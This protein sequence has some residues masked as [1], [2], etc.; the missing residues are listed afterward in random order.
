MVEIQV[1]RSFDTDFRALLPATMF[2]TIEESRQGRNKNGVR[3]FTKEN[4]VE[5][6]RDQKWDRVK[7]ICRELSKKIKQFGLAFVSFSSVKPNSVRRNDA[8]VLEKSEKMA[9]AVK[10][11]QTKRQPNIIPAWKKDASFYRQYLEKDT[12]SGSVKPEM[13][14]RILKM[15]STSEDGPRNEAS[16][17]RS[18]KMLIA[19][20]STNTDL[21]EITNYEPTVGNVPVN[22]VKDGLVQFRRKLQ[23][24]IRKEGQGIANA[25][26]KGLRSKFEEQ[27]GYKMDK[28]MKLEFKMASLRAA[29]SLLSSEKLPVQRANESKETPEQKPKR[30]SRPGTTK[31]KIFPE[32]EIPKRLPA[33]AYRNCPRCFVKFTANQINLHIANCVPDH[34][35]IARAALGAITGSSSP[36]TSANTTVPPTSHAKKHGRTNNKEKE[37]VPKTKKATTRKRA[38]GPKRPKRCGTR[39]PSTS[40]TRPVT[41][42]ISQTSG[43]NRGCYSPRTS[44]S[45]PQLNSR[46]GSGQSRPGPSASI[47]QGIQDLSGQTRPGPSDSIMQ[48]N[49]DLSGQT[50]PGPSASTMQ[51]NQELFP[52]P[53]CHDSYDIDLIQV[54]ASLCGESY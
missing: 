19:A 47:M 34:L 22:E 27:L 5:G 35:Q 41:Q 50:R 46:V 29:E 2:R 44:N 4:F 1:R 39:V 25:S 36:S 23:K 24:F 53:I 43:T 51:G 21:T 14:D 9:S 38:T 54:H 6:V 8:S 40:L 7:I 30:K 12:T 15:S 52:C 11:K 26:M 13:K 48:G 10:G 18:A 20:S 49:Q 37:P 16:F 17:G 33:S 45:S 31:R 3:M 42:S 32:K 28:M